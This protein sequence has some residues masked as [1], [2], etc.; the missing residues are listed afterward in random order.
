MIK[1]ISA[2]AACAAL[3][4][5]ASSMAGGLF[6]DV[7][8]K[9][10]DKAGETFGERG[11]SP[12]DWRVRG[13]LGPG[14]ATE[15]QIRLERTEKVAIVGACDHDCT[16]MDITVTSP[17]GRDVASDTLEDDVPIVTLT[18]RRDGQYTV[19]VVM[20]GCSSRTCNYGLE[21]FIA[22]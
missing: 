6:E 2:A 16:D 18:P 19:R 21:L 4:V 12:A 10:L 8:D 17:G 3:M 9:Q 15:Y 20:A 14:E 22:N 5:P 1:A 11:Y 7:V 13:S